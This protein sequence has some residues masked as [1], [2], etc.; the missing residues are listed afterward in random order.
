MEGFSESKSILGLLTLDL[1][2]NS[3][4]IGEEA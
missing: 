1:T 3:S 2:F 4:G